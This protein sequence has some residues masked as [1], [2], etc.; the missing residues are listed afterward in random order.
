VCTSSLFALA[1]ARPA[2]TE[3]DAH[4]GVF[5]DYA[6]TLKNLLYFDVDSRKVKSAQHARYDE[7]MNDVPA[8]P[9]NARLVRF[10]QQ[11][12]AFP[13]EATLL[14]PLDLDVSENPFQD[15]RTLSVL[16]GGEN[17]HL[18]FVFSKY[19]HRLRAYLSELQ[20]RILE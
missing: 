19:S 15:L 14:E 17:S 16:A 9:P 11:G 13:A 18:G 6:Q 4:T 3:I 5:L 10:A 12:E 2:K 7:G 1:H 8:P 20:P